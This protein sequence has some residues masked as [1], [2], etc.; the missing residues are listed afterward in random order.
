MNVFLQELRTQR[1]SVLVWSLSL[2]AFGSLYLLLYGAIKN[3]IQVFEDVL[4]NF[5]PAA[6][7]ALGFVVGTLKSVTGFYAFAFTYVVL[8]GAVQAMNLGVGA[9][10]R[11]IGGSTADFLLTKPVARWS[12]LAQKALAVLVAL[13]VTNAV[14]LAVTIPVAA[15]QQSD[16][17]AGQFLALS[18]TLFFV[19]LI[20]ASLGLLY[21]IAAK[22]VKSVVAV[23]LPAVFAF[24]VVGMLGAIIGEDKIR[25]FTPFKY[26]DTAYILE[27]AT[28][29]TTFCLLA[30]A[31]VVAAVAAGFV[32]FSK[33]DVQ[34]L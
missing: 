24:F 28:Y 18:A 3:D 19:Q 34:A 13:V 20:F 5:P 2:A 17:D 33:K 32:V 21:G 31:I 29:E 22:K 27:N 25:Y 11:E 9:I 30:G 16:F 15:A 26:F 6:K 7:A 10:G 14:Y 1:R 4:Q 8:C 12:I 23:S